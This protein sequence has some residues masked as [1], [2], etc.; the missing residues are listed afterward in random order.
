MTPQSYRCCMSTCLLVLYAV[1]FVVWVNNLLKVYLTMC[2]TSNCF[3]LFCVYV[4]FLWPSPCMFFWCSYCLQFGSF[5]WCVQTVAFI[6][7]P[8]GMWH[9]SAEYDV[10]L[11]IWISDYIFERR[12]SSCFESPRN[13]FTVLGSIPGQGKL[14]MSRSSTLK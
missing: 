14:W 3:C 9:L 2:S 5:V 7:F 4:S 10:E 6:F 13:V 1:C 8:F 11:G 12:S